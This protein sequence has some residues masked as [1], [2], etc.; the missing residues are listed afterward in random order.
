MR[1][2][3]GLRSVNSDADRRQFFGRVV[4]AGLPRLM[5]AGLAMLGCRRRVWFTPYLASIEL[6][7]AADK[8]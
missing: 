7:D 1:W 8:G 2:A 3:K 4:G 6:M 5:L